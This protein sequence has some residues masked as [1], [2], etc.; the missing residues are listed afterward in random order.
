MKKIYYLSFLFLVST[1]FA[2]AQY[3][4][5]SGSNS[6]VVGD[7]HDFVFVINT[8]EG[9]DGKN[10]TWDYTGL[11]KTDKVLTTNMYVSSVSDK[12][13]LIPQANMV[14]EEA[15]NL[16]FFK[17]TNQGM[18]QVGTIGGC[19]VVRYDKPIVKLSFPFKY[20]D[21]VSG[22]YSGVIINQDNN[23]SIISGTY[24]V[25]ADAYGTLLLPGN[26]TIKNAL[27][28]K[29]TYT[30]NYSDQKEITYRWYANGVR[31][32]IL[33]VI[34]YESAQKSF[35]SQTA[36]YAHAVSSWDQSDEIISVG[37]SKLSIDQIEVF[38][39]PFSG[40]FTIR[41]K[42]EKAGNVKVDIIDTDGKVIRNCVNQNLEAGYNSNIIMMD[43]NRVGS[44]FIRLTTDE[45]VVIKK[46]IQ[47]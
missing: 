11:Q 33:V 9:I 5:S 18:D 14:I 27:R 3:Q 29:Q 36:L 19:S 32:P 17:V 16:F 42:L 37:S 22:D 47:N 1:L 24:E 43:K 26:V 8:T 10:V 25:V 2:N 13:A 40:Q 23:E 7:K 28:V 46:V 30:F 6:F 41:Y 4:L 15:G 31:Y 21:K 20:A 35:I 39:N 44:Y 12:S 34:K 38:P 45:N